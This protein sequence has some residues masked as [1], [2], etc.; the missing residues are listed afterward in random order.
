[1][2]WFRFTD[3]DIAQ[4]MEALGIDLFAK[5][6]NGLVPGVEAAKKLGISN[7][8]IK[9]RVQ[10]GD[11]VPVGRGFYKGTVQYFFE[12]D[13]EFKTDFRN[14]RAALTGEQV[15]AAFHDK[16]PARVVAQ[17]LGVSTGC[18][19]QLRRGFTYAD[20]TGGK[21]AAAE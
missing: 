13:H 7:Q 2:G 4:A 21:K 12:P 16:R 1:M 18:I 14:P 15:L 5:D 11:E 6:T 10:K 8:A 17:E 3:E 20:I 9:L 19:H